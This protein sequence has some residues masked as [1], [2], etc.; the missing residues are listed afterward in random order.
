MRR[1]TLVCV[2]VAAIVGA[3]P[4]AAAAAAGNVYAFVSSTPVG[5]ID[6]FD[7]GSTGALAAKTPASVPTVDKSAL[8]GFTPDGRHLYVSAV[9]A[10]ASIGLFDVA[11]DGTLSAKSPATLPVQ[12]GGVGA[13]VSPDG[14]TLY[15]TNRDNNT[16]SLFDVGADGALTPKGPPTFTTPPM[17]QMVVLSPDGR[18]AYIPHL[19]TGNE[20]ISQYDVAADGR[21][22]PK[23]TSTVP[24]SKDTA[25]MVI[26]PNGRSAYA[27]SNTDNNLRQYSIDGSGRLAAKVPATISIPGATW[28]AIAPDGRSL[29]VRAANIIAQLD[30]D[31]DGAVSPKTPATVPALGPI[32]TVVITPDGRSVYTT[33]GTNHVLQFDVGAGGTLTA[34]TPPSV[35]GGPAMVDLAVRPNQGP[36]ASFSANSAAAGSATGFDGSGS[37]DPETAVGRYDWD[38]GDGATASDAGARPSHVYAPAGTY[39][40]RLTV[41]DDQGCSTAQ[42]F[43]GLTA[44]CNGIGAAMTTRMV[45]VPAASAGAAPTPPLVCCALP[46]SSDFRIVALTADRGGTITAV[47]DTQA[48]GQAD[49]TAS[50]RVRAPKRRRKAKASAR[51]SRVKTVA[52]GTGSAT[53]AGAGRLT[54]RIGARHAALTALRRLRKLRVRVAITFSAGGPQVTNT[55]SVTVKAPKRR[56]HRRH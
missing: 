29:Y 45:T 10:S 15:I 24:A 47:I 28:A 5:E 52:Y 51:K 6:P 42:V 46:P 34:K 35:T 20:F 27:I 18:S 12:D 23:T 37:S 22:T 38:F 32:S 4:G 21:L 50:T 1:G 17:D 55:R 8:G 49:G 33:D 53:T 36:T 41:T 54:M 39:T 44:L 11:A 7:I 2:A 48:A 26:A 43:N 40:A 3:A 14:R 30:V 25:V 13:T 56:K 31:P 19:G 9:K 16:V